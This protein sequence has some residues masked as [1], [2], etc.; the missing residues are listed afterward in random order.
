M[1]VLTDKAD[2]A[3]RGDQSHHRQRQ[4]GLARSALADDAH[5]LAGAHLQCCRID[6]LHMPDRALQQPLVDREPD[7]QVFGLGDHR[8]A[9]RHRRRYPHGLGTKQLLR[10]GVLRRVKDPRHGAGLD[11]LALLH[12][13]DPV[14]DAPHD[15]QI[16][17]DEQQGHAFVALQFGQQ[18]Q[19]LRLNRHIE[20][21]GGLVGDQDVGLVGQRHGDHHPLS[22]PTRQLMRIGVQTACRLADADTLQQVH[23]PVARGVSGQRLVQFEA[24]AQLLFQ[25]VQ[26]IQRCHRLLEDEA[27][28]VTP[29]LPQPLFIRADHLV[30]VI[31]DAARNLGRAP[32]KRHRGQRGDRLAR[33][34]FPHQ[35][36]RLAT[37]DTERHALDR[38]DH[39][40]V[41]PK[42]DGQVTHLQK[43]H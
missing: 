21:R 12:H 1:H 34:G 19:N 17:G 4:R 9:R 6:G 26:R 7:A 5:G 18:F 32:K 35:R 10:I 25:R 16:M 29:H 13:A 41:L 11:D 15:P 22:L 33:P 23:D 31:C 3:F 38:R 8:R 27:D 30:P 37:L 28:I 2:P 14:G 42:P 20:R 43:A 39:L 40:P 36:H 24:F